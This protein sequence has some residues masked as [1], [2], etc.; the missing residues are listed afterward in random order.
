MVARSDRKSCIASDKTTFNLVPCDGGFEA[1]FV[2]FLD[3]CRDVAAFEKNAGPQK[4]MI[5]YLAP[6]G[7][8]AIFWPDFLIRLKNNR[9]VLAELKGIEDSTSAV[10]AKAA[11]EWCKAASASGAKW[12]YMYVTAPTFEANHDF[13][14]EALSRGAGRRLLALVDTLTSKQI[15]L[16]FD[17]KPEVSRKEKADK[18]LSE[19]DVTWL[20]EGLR[21]H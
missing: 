20:P 16:P 14:V 8:P 6:N 13:T 1:E 18:Y 21:R 10:K 4:L 9:H 3:T 15:P 2:D 11:I 7:R 17:E 19:I 12:D 5:D